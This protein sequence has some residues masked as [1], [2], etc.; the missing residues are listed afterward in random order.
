MVHSEITVTKKGWQM[1]KITK[2]LFDFL[3]GGVVLLYQSVLE[4]KKISD[5]C[6]LAHF[7]RTPRSFLF[8]FFNITVFSSR[9]RQVSNMG[10]G[11]GLKGQ[12][13]GHEKASLYEFYLFRTHFLRKFIEGYGPVK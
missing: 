2:H 12:V 9:T 11:F 5:C 7:T 8:S 1:V 4:T 3:K 13:L 10:S 6:I